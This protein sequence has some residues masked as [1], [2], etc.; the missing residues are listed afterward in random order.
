MADRKR[1]KMVAILKLLGET[2]TPL[3]SADVATA[4]AVKGQEASER[5]VRLYLLDMDRQGL[6]VSLGRRRGHTLTEKGRAELQAGQALARVGMLSARIDTMTYGMTFDLHRRSGGVVVNV[7]L[8][9]RAML[10]RHIEEVC[11]V[12]AKGYAMGHMAA[13][14][15]AGEGLGGLVVPEGM[16][17]FCTV[18]SVTVNGVLLKHGIPTHSRFGGLIELRNGQALRFVELIHY[19]GTSIDPLEVFIRGGMTDYRGAVAS[20]CGR[21]GASFREL[22]AQS[23]D[24]VQSLCDNMA[25]IGLGA[26]LT[27]GMPGQP[28][29]DVPVSDGRVGAVIVGGLNPIAILAE[30]GCRVQPRAMCGLMEYTQLFRYNELP[31]RLRRLNA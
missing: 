14:L 10:A 20:G 12:F 8:V 9:E 16:V 25:D 7:S 27:L 29:M 15:G 21:I 5:A 26:L 18:C 23:R 30:H 4:L 24:L 2:G 6:T 13:L 11:T 3:T 28:V 22:P 19:D 17:G 31:E 1:V